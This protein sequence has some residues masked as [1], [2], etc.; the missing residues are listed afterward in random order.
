[1][2]FTHSIMFHHF[3]GNKHCPAQ[4][5]LSAEEFEEMLDWLGNRYNLVNANEYLLKFEKN[6]LQSNDICLSF[7]DA[8]LCQFDVAVPVLRQ[9]NIQAFFFVY[10]SVFTGN[11]ELLEIFRYFRTTCFDNIDDFYRIFFTTAK[12]NL[13]KINASIA[14]GSYHTDSHEPAEKIL[15]NVSLYQSTYETFKGLDYLAAFPFYSNNDKW[16]RYLRD[17]VLGIENYKS[18]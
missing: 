8:L 13:D 4:G 7:D 9:R 3:H 2:S 6:C 11:Y 15:R 10:S 16:Y 12:S 5:S 17:Q 14:E 1:M 18:F